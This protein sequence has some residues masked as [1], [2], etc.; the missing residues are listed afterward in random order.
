MRKR[1]VHSAAQLDFFDELDA[2]SVAGWYRCQGLF[3]AHYLRNSLL[4]SQDLPS[5]DVCRALYERIR[6]R[7]HANYAGL[8]AQKEA[9]TQTQFLNPTLIDLG[10]RFL[11]EQDLPSVIGQKRPDYCLY[12]TES[13]K[14][15]AAAAAGTKGVFRLAA[16]AMEAKKVQHPLD[17]ASDKETPGLFPS[18]Q[19]QAYLANAKDDSGRYFNW[20]ILS[21]GNSW[22][23]YA[24]QARPNAYFEFDLAKERE[25]CSLD[26]FRLFVALFGPT[27]FVRDQ[28]SRCRLDAIREE[29]LTQQQNLETN[30]RKR[31]FVVLE[32]LA[33]GFFYEKQNGL[34]ESDLEQIYEVSLIFLYRV[35]FILY[36]ESLGLLPAK[37]TGIGANRRYRDEFSLA[38]HVEKLRDLNAYA[39]DAFYGLYEQLVRLFDL[40]SGAN[41]AQCGKLGV[42]RF[43]GGLFDPDGRPEIRE[44]RIGE[45]TLANV[46]RQLAFVQ[47]PARARE[48]HGRLTTNETVDYGTLEVRQLGDIYEGLLGGKLAVRSGGYLELVDDDGENHQKGIFYTPDWVVQYLVREALRP[49]IEEIEL[50]SDVQKALNSQSTE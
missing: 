1:T 44:W 11:P 40:L 6:D 7:W 21:N 22:R 27:A 14:Q 24:E 43:N 46:L 33:A 45:Q 9:Y 10:W 8:R 31:I 16:T 18:Q 42:T 23:L 29:S 15:T 20:A 4:K 3:S 17:R 47:P 50:R 2:E 48:K 35:L 30:L 25:F 37:A 49:L 26:D 5:E 12:L 13:D 36:A 39:D 32:D 34:S 19:I 41:E 28:E 38:R